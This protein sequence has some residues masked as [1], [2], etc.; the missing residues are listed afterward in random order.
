MISEKIVVIDDNEKIIKSLKIALIEYEIIDFPSGEEAIEYL[1][2]PN[3]I[4]LILLDVFMEGMD[5]ISVLQELKKMNKDL[6][7][8][9]MTAYGSKDIVLQALRHRADDFIEKPFNIKELKEKILKLLKEKIAVPKSG[10]PPTD[11]IDRIKRFINRNYNNASLSYISNEMSLSPKYLSRMFN[12]K[13]NCSFRTYKLRVKI[14]KA[15][16]FLT[17]TGLSVSDISIELGYQNPE[18]FMRIF[19]K[20]TKLTPMQYRKNFVSARTSSKNINVPV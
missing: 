1:K 12:Q 14:E 7:I 10:S 8:I 19:K 3:E 18:S 16:Y 20:A 2:A 9:I 6:A 4:N 11:Q 15:K 13:N 5:G 17:Q